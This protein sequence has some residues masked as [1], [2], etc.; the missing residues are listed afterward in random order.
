MYTL[1]KVKEE[2]ILTVTDRLSH[3]VTQTL[4]KNAILCEGWHKD[5]GFYAKGS[6]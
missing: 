2:G 3:T 5:I 6:A 4:T 1:N